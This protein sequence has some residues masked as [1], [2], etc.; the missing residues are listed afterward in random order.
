[1]KGRWRREVCELG[2]HVKGTAIAGGGVDVWVATVKLEAVRGESR[3]K[4]TEEGRRQRCAVAHV[5]GRP[6]AV[7]R[8][9]RS[10]REE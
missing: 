2:F 1:M 10:G 7:G 6:P 9:S 3:E 8:C 5:A 4:R